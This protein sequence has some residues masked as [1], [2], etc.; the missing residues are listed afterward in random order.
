MA[1]S[2]VALLSLFAAPPEAQDRPAYLFQMQARATDSIQLHGIPYRAQPGDILLFD[3]HSTLTAA[4]YRYVGTGGPLHAAIVFRRNDGSLGT[5]EAGTNA[6][7]K[8]FNFD[9]QSRLHGFDG[10]ILVRRPLKAMTAAQSE[11]L[12][13]FAMAQKGKSYAIGRL[14]MQATP[15]RPRQS[16][17]APFFGRTVLDRDRWI[18]SEL[19][20]AALASAGVWA[21]TA[22]PA[23]LMYPRDLCYDERFDLSP[24]YAAPAL[25]YP[26]AKVDRIDKGVRV[27]N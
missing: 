19:V 3:D 26:R 23:N 12:T 17:L 13:I 24:Y 20:V 1:A 5:L 14:L 6:V 10:T 22:Y 15:L 27:G 21:P 9:L 2:F 18:C 16:F 11:K 4:V 7:M 8:V 25:W